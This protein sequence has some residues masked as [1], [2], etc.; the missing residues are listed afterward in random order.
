VTLIFHSYGA[1]G[2]QGLRTYFVG[3]VGFV[4]YERLTPGSHFDWL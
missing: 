2:I 4:V 3:F 1:H